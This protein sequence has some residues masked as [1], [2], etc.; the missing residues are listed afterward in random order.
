M[1]LRLALLEAGVVPPGGDLYAAIPGLSEPCW[2]SG[3]KKA[4][5]ALLFAER[6][7]VRLPSG[8]AESLPKGLTGPQFTA[9]FLSAYPD[10]EPVLWRGIGHRLMFAESCI[11]IASILRLTDQGI[12]AL[13]MHDGLMVP[14]SKWEEA[15]KAMHEA[16]LEVV[17]SHLP[18][19]LELL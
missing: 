18:I 2:R 19:S 7:L 3:V 9:A 8:L 13:A 6:P 1:F 14:M 4:T 5:A 17:G 15:R 12:P 11:L 16:C 10:L